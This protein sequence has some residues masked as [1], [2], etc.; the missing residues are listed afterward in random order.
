MSHMVPRANG[1]VLLGSLRWDWLWWHVDF[2]THNTRD[3][4]RLTANLH[5]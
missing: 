5:V 2:L 3:S 4:K 1:S